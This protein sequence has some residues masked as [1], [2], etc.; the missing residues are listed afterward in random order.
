MRVNTRA[1]TIARVSRISL[2]G[3]LG[4]TFAFIIHPIDPQ[5]DARRKFS[6]LAAYSRNTRLIFL[7]IVPPVFI[8]EITWITSLP[9]GKEIKGW[10]YYLSEYPTKYNG[11]ARMDSLS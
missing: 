5:W 10:F 1:C 6:F 8:S 2:L 7:N 4:G 3:N 9:T 11:V